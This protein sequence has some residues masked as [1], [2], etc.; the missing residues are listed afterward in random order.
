M[1]IGGTEKALLSLLHS[2]E[3]R[4][5]KI[6]LLVF[7]KGGVLES[8]IPSFVQVKHLEHFDIMKPI[9]ENPP[10]HT[11]LKYIKSFRFLAAFTFFLTYFKIKISGHW[12]YN[13]KTILNNVP[14][15]GI[16][17]IAIA[18]AGPSDFISYFVIKKVT[19]NRKIQWIHF[20]IEKVISNFNFGNKF[21]PY[22]QQIFCVSKSSQD[23]FVRNYP[24]FAY[25]TEVFHNIILTDEIK[26]KAGSGNSF[27]YDYDGFKIVT[28]GRFTK[29]KGHHLI[30]EVVA[31]LKSDG[32][33]F[34]W[35]LIGDGNEKGNVEKMSIDLG[36]VE[37]LKFL[38]LKE[39]PY[40]YMKDCDI[41]V[42][43]SL[44]EGFGITVEEAKVFNKPI[45]VTNF[46]SATDLI[47][48]QKTGFITEISSYG[49]YEAVKTLILNEGL[50]RKFQENL[51]TREFSC[52]DD[53]NKI[54]I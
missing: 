22:F 34:R 19:A 52:Y 25:K 39:N 51:A 35:Y 41:Y 42:Q 49:I 47:D 2:L 36:L 53:I 12:Y 26:K 50:R 31:K 9:V 23:I 5:L 46:A 8:S 48:N 16:Y 54:L 15:F 4:S 11:I 28:V 18:F 43:P 30:P 7:E 38:G 13:Y 14:H 37:N 44:H 24:H 20:D 10:Q 17:D 1:D 27:G 32:F 40:P 29:E 3:K 6:T 33:V 21:Y 45:V